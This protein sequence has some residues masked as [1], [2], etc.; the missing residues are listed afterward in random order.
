MNESQS[1]FQSISHQIM[2]ENLKR[3]LRNAS[4]EEKLY[5][6]TDLAIQYIMD[7]EEMRDMSYLIGKC[8]H[9]EFAT[10]YSQTCCTRLIENNGMAMLILANLAERC[11]RSLPHMEVVSTIC[12]IF[13]NISEL[14]ETRNFVANWDSL[15]SMLKII[16]Q[17]MN[18]FKENKK[19]F[20]IF[21][22]C[23]S[24]LW[25]LC[26]QENV[27]MIFKKKNYADKLISFEKNAKC[28]SNTLSKTTSGTSLPTYSN[29]R[30]RSSSVPSSAKKFTKSSNKRLAIRHGAAE[31]SS[32]IVRFFDD[33]HTAITSLN[34][35]VKRCSSILE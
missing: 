17:L 8:K 10:R 5:Y 26:H 18:R 34:K 12:D 22:K 20:Y 7:V 9:L 11:N 21:S 14:L 32:N 13:I 23:C 28:T 19:P 24:F 33:Y 25:K 31:L 2:N 29:F 6:R 27:L 3:A 30:G 35:E 15:D 4:E 1:T 16:F